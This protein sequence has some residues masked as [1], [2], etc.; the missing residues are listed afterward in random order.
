MDRENFIVEEVFKNT[1]QSKKHELL[2]KT[3][4]KI[5]LENYNKT[6]SEKND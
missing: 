3:I 2:K 1:E 6:K 5:S 4:L